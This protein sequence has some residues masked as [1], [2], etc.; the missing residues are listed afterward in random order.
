MFIQKYN[1]YYLQFYIFKDILSTKCTDEQLNECLQT[2]HI[3]NTGLTSQNPLLDLL[4]RLP[5]G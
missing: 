5:Q 1:I 3:S 4:L 2:H